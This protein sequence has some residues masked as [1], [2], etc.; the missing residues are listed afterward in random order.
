[1]VCIDH[2]ITGR[3]HLTKR[4]DKQYHNHLW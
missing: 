4:L 3:I 1:M 2:N